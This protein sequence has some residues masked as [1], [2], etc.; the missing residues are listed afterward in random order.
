MEASKILKANLLDLVFDNRNKDYGAYEL[1][2]TY[3]QRIKRSLLITLGVGVLIFAGAVLANSTKSNGA[4]MYQ[5]QEYTLQTIDE[6]KEPEPLPEPERKPEPPPEPE[7]MV[8]L[9]TPT[10]ADE[11]PEPPPTQEDI[12][13]ANI[14]TINVDGVKP[15]G[16]ILDEPVPLGDN[17]GIINLPP[18]EP[19]IF[20]KVEIAAKF[21]GD[22]TRY[23]T[24][25]LR[26]EV[27]VDNNAPAGKYKVQIKFVVDV[28]G[29]LSDIV[30]LTNVGYGMEQE[31][32]RVLKQSKKWI[33]A[34]QNTRHVKAYHIQ[35][36]VFEVMTEE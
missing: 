24:R 15:T 23:L 14:G 5:A 1:R 32:I 10:L 27:P 7:R 28:D 29:S 26:A 30:A 13:D 9:T 8:Q 3:P 19:E 12:A 36:I 34:F 31:A 18:K 22:W 4:P 16:Q 6:P 2:V 17:T 25:N 21:D 20:D 11:V 33:P 35:N